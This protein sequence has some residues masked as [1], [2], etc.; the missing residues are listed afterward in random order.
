MIDDINNAYLDWWHGN[1]WS[2]TL[3]EKRR[4]RS[5]LRRR[6]DIL[7]FT[8]SRAQSAH[9]NRINVGRVARFQL[10][11]PLKKLKTTRSTKKRVRDE[12][13]IKI[14]TGWNVGMRVEW[15]ACGRRG[16]SFYRMWDSS[17]GF[18][19]FP[20]LAIDALVKITQGQFIGEAARS[21]LREWIPSL[22]GVFCVFIICRCARHEKLF[23][24]TP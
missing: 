3:E 6:D 20:T 10:Q 24:A 19:P 22:N 1:K 21:G 9:Q 16:D 5:S 15:I 23:K 12:W 2:N 11:R 14:I 8:H 4:E 18:F 7:L 13:S 17:S